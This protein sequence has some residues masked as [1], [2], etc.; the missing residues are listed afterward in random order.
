MA[1]DNSIVGIKDDGMAEIN[2]HWDVKTTTIVDQSILDLPVLGQGGLRD[3]R[4]WSEEIMKNI[5][6]LRVELLGV[7]DAI[8]EGGVDEVVCNMVGPRE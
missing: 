1:S 8:E 2:V 5:E 3:G 7:F 6:Y 4:F